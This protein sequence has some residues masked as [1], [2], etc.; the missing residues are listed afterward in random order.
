MSETDGENTSGIIYSKQKH[1]H[2]ST[3]MF[4]VIFKKGDPVQTFMVLTG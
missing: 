1:N 2:C 4:N 3:S